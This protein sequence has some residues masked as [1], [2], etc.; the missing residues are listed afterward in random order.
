MSTR[1]S[2]PPATR[3]ICPHCKQDLA[4]VLLHRYD[5]HPMRFYTVA[6][7]NCHKVV[8]C[9]IDPGTVIQVVEQATSE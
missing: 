2:P 7:G 4:K 1:R 3:G 8:G 6:C 5:V 9:M